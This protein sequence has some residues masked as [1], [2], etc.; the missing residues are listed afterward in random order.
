VPHN[1]THACKGH[2]SPGLSLHAASLLG[3]RRRFVHLL[4]DFVGYARIPKYAAGLVGSYTLP[5]VLRR[6]GSW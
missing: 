6:W 4:D 1:L 2:P 5:D 3:L